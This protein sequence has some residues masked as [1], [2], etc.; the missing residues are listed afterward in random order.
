MI[1]Q[2]RDECCWNNK[3]GCDSRVL[4]AARDQ[5]G[6]TDRQTK[7][8]IVRRR[9]GNTYG[10]SNESGR[11]ERSYKTTIV[12]SVKMI[13]KEA[14]LD[15]KQNLQ[16][17]EGRTSCDPKFN[18]ERHKTSEDQTSSRKELRFLTAPEVDCKKEK[19]STV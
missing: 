1:R 16:R 4:V 11:R 9:G 8:T 17:P 10:E 5:E 3:K 7:H 15:Q 2:Q 14:S 12:D 19:F 13:I 18:S 6:H